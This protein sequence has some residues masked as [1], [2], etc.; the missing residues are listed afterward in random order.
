MNV[1]FLI[2]ETTWVVELAEGFSEYYMTTLESIMKKS[3][4]AVAALFV[5]GTTLSFAK[6]NGGG[7]GQ[8]QN[9]QKNVQK[10]EC[11][12]QQKCDGSG[13]KEGKKKQKRLQK[14]NGSGNGQKK[15]NNKK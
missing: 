7:T 13:N 1:T 14:K 5:L 8:G 12:Q 4:I 11:K 15:S 6:G 9:K 10:R 2:Y 3:I